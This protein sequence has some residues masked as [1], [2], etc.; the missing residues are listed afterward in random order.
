MSKIFSFYKDDL[1]KAWYDSSN[2]IYSECDD[3]DNELKTVRVTFKDGRTYSYEKVPVYDYLS[4][5]NSNSQ[6]KAL[7]SFLK[8]YECNKVENKDVNALN[9]E[10]EALMN[11]EGISVELSESAINI[12]ENK[13]L[14]YNAEISKETADV[15]AQILD[16]L[17]IKVNKN[18]NDC[19]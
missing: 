18:I 12:Y 13:E 10:L 8:K 5:R 3:K 11:P 14:K 19:N 7:N 6:G 16:V 15:I 17:N 2:I 1:D 9:E 4:F